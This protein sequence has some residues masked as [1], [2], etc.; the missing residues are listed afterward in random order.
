[1]LDRDEQGGAGTLTSE[2]SPS[3][4]LTTSPVKLMQFLG[5]TNISVLKMDCE[6]CEYS[7]ARDLFQHGDPRFFSK[8]EQF[9]FEAHVSRSWT[10]TVDHI[11]YLGLLFHILEREGFQLIRYAVLPCSRADEVLGC[12]DELIQVD[13]PCGSRRMC[14]EYSFARLLHPTP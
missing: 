1:M 5:H 7:I 10:K 4:W 3:S 14:H 6:G 11:H 13:Y 2:I 12:L 9:A 8:V